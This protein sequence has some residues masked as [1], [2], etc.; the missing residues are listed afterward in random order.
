MAI[1]P[2]HIFL[3]QH[4]DLLRHVFEYIFLTQDLSASFFWAR[5]EVEYFVC[6][7]LATRLLVALVL[8]VAVLG[9]SMTVFAL[10]FVQERE[11]PR[12]GRLKKIRNCLFSWLFFFAAKVFLL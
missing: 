6:E 5:F 2:D 12:E 9:H 3:L 8:T 11:I 10:A 4:L 7:R 1:L